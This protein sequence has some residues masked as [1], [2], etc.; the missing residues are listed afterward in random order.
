MAELSAALRWRTRVIISAS[1]MVKLSPCAAILRYNVARLIPIWS[2][3]CAM[4]TPCSTMAAFNFRMFNDLTLFLSRICDNY[5][6]D[7]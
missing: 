5:S 2:A 1:P 3:S 7:S 6:I 4:L